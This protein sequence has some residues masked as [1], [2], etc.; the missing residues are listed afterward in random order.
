MKGCPMQPF[1]DLEITWMAGFYTA[2]FDA[3]FC[4]YMGWFIGREQLKE[5]F[6][7]AALTHVLP[8]LLLQSLMA[9]SPHLL[10]QDDLLSVGF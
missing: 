4:R 3:P 7:N 5:R 10:L 2:F 9:F 8:K 1:L 6:E